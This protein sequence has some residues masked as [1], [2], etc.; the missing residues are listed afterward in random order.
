MG[1]Q[2]ANEQ[3]MNIVVTIRYILGQAITFC[4]PLIIIGFIAPSITKP[5][6]NASRMLG[7]AIVCVCASSV[8]AAF[9][10]KNRICNCD[11]NPFFGKY[12]SVL[13]ITG[14]VCN[15]STRSTRRYHHDIFRFDHGALGFYETGTAL[16]LTSFALQDSFGTVCNVTRDG[17]LTMILTGYAKRY[18]IEKQKISVEL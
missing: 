8:F 1:G 3:F 4:L 10:S 6:H 13:C 14:S 17:A 5:G 16:L 18:H 11:Y 9:I 12:D 2:I 7:V 15:R